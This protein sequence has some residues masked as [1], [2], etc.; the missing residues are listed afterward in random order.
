MEGM[1]RR[2]DPRV[3]GLCMLEEKEPSLTTKNSFVSQ[4]GIYYEIMV[5]HL[6]PVKQGL[7]HPLFFPPPLPFA[8]LPFR[9]LPLVHPTPPLTYTH[10][11]PPL[12][13]PQ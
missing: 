13:S 8:S 11:P 2:E 9:L 5:T 4:V 3:S 7:T 6:K 12:H 10:T 1:R